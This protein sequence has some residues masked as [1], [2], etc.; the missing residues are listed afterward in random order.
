MSEFTSIQWC[1]STANPAMGCDGCELFPRNP[2]IAEAVARVLIEKGYSVAAGRKDDVRRL[3]PSQVAS[4]TYHARHTIASTV[5]GRLPIRERNERLAVEQLVERVIA[6]EFKCYAGML[7]LWRG[8]NHVKPEKKP[9]PGY[10]RKFEIVTKYPGR[11]RAAAAWTDLRG[12]RRL[13]RQ[14]GDKERPARPW[15]DE[16]PRLIFISDMADLLSAA[17]DFDYIREEVIENVTSE[18]GRRHVWLW[19]TKRPARMAKFSEWLLQEGIGWPDN[20][21]AM[22]SITSGKTIG[23]VDQLRKV[24]CRFRGLSVEPLWEQVTLNLKD[25]DWVI[26]GGE[27]ALRQA[28]AT[29]FDIAWARDLLQ[30]SRRAKV[31]YFVKQLGTSP[32]DGT[33]ALHLEDHHG[34]D[35]TEW[36]A[37]LRIREFPKAFRKLR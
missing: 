4:D 18:N 17:V 13:A 27:S 30:Q 26:A 6:A 34:G 22:T 10:A 12:T 7:H 24:K 3:F 29:P 31:A 33:A 15:L 36:P 14:V 28:D 9:N 21:V 23:R 11:M 25:I 35:W 19:L 5:A 32:V 8:T 1:D 2:Q 37:D 20:L 16:L